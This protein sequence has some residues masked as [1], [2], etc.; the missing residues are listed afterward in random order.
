MSQAMIIFG[1]LIGTVNFATSFDN[2]PIGIVLGPN[3]G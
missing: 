2:K 1:D 3:T